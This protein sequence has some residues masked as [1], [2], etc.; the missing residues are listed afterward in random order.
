L[1]AEIATFYENLSKV[2]STKIERLVETPFCL[3]MFSKF[4]LRDRSNII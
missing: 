2:F 3:G 4:G 1:P